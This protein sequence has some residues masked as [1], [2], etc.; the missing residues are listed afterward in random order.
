MLSISNQAQTSKYMGSRAASVS[1][2]PGVKQPIQGS[3]WPLRER[4]LCFNRPIALFLKHSFS[5]SLPSSIVKTLKPMYKWMDIGVSPSLDPMLFVLA[6]YLR[7]SRDPSA[8]LIYVSL[9]SL[10][11]SYKIL[12]LPHPDNQGSPQHRGQQHA[13]LPNCPNPQLTGFTSGVC[14]R[15]ALNLQTSRVSLEV[16]ILLYQSCSAR[17]TGEHHST[18]LDLVVI[19][20]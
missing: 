16:L 18:Q 13:V 11:V 9:H 14:P 6:C 19:L 15:L 7:L 3:C 1:Q 17:I 12:S 10:A 4:F 20:K 2:Q 8:S 5:N